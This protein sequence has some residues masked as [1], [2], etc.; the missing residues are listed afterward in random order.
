MLEEVGEEYQP[1]D[2]L[3]WDYLRAPSGKVV[4]RR[5]VIDFD[6]NDWDFS[7]QNIMEFGIMYA[8]HQHNLAGSLL[9]KEV[10]DSTYTWNY[11]YTY[12][13]G[14][15]I[16]TLAVVCTDRTVKLW[17][18]QLGRV[19]RREFI[20]AT[21]QDPISI[22]H[23][24]YKGSQVVQEYDF[25]L[26]EVGEEYQPKDDLTWDYLRAPSGKVVRRREVTDFDTN[27][28]DDY[29]HIK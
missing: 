11:T 7:A 21:T 20:N 24:Y 22:T 2:D 27:D 16:R 6:T 1:K 4:R 23:Y 8:T 14:Y 15:R 29:L 9:T 10:I 19:F 5:E 12:D 3:T 17:Y 18:D 26:E 28:W 25:M 13:T